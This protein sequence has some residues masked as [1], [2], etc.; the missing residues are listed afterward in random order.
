MLLHSAIDVH[1]A[2]FAGSRSFHR[3]R[4]DQIEALAAAV[5]EGG[6]PEAVRRHRQRGKG[7][8]RE[9]IERLL[10]P[11]TPFLELSALAGHGLYSGACP[12][13]GL[14]TGIGLVCGHPVVVIAND[15]TVKGGTYFPMTVR[16][17]LRAL[18]VARAFRLPCLCLVDSGGAYLPL[19]DEVF[20]DRDH[21]GRIFFQMARLNAE[22]L[23][24][25]AAVLGSC[26]AG[27]AYVPAMSDEVVMVRGSSSIFL[28]G[29]PLV[30]AATGERVT[31]EELGGADVHC[32]RSGV[33]DHLAENEPDALERLR[34]LVAELGPA[35]DLAPPYPPEEPARPPD[36][37][38]GVAPV[39][40]RTPWDP[41]EVLVR[42]LDGGRFAEF[43]AL[44][45]TSLVCGSGRILGYPVA[46]LANHGPLDAAA[47]G[48]AAHFVALADQRHVPLLFLQDIAGFHVG[49][50]HEAGGI[51]REGAK[52]VRAVAN[53]AVPKLTVVVGGS[54][55]AG[56]Y[57]MCGRA[58]DPHLLLLW[59]SARVS[60]M[61][62]DA[63]GAVLASV[64]RGQAEERGEPPDEAAIERLV[65]ET[66]ARYARE[67]DALHGS[68]RLWDDGII[69]PPDTRNVLGLA[70]AT[71]RGGV[72]LRPTTAW[73]VFRM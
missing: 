6:G 27:G 4:W 19:Q 58:Y 60:V 16:K 11:D 50:G 10:D 37:L 28:A 8:P 13:G 47:A 29:P 38:W 71:L 40:P 64:K 24:Q 69:A 68:A 70:L 20:P 21:F 63:A 14:V 52:M 72:P 62:G 2:G 43:R 55:G 25:L 18:E 33:A 9:R 35:P 23:P 26:T 17:H 61:S 15:A 59:P 56:N 22:G 41:R 67:G 1:D 45:G 32:R 12:G 5:R 46:V 66:T 31:A 51:A 42:L 7:L 44:Y 57:A 39:D 73:G 36:E 48:K 54:H 53:A 65:A 34:S 30:R 3:D 49:R